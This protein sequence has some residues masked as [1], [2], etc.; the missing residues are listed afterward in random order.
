M[1]TD[2]HIDIRLTQAQA[3]LILI[4]LEDLHFVSSTA[5]GPLGQRL[6]E[7]EEL[8][9]MIMDAGLDAGFGDVQT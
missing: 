3:N 7:I 2:K 1:A 4:G 6:P 9:D 8:M 5:G